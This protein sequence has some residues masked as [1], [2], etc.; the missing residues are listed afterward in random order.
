M[1]RNRFIFLFFLSLFF[2][3]CGGENCKPCKEVEDIKVS[4]VKRKIIEENGSEVSFARLFY[5][6]HEPVVLYGM[7]G[8]AYKAYFEN[9]KWYKKTP[10]TGIK[11]RIDGIFYHG[12]TLILEIDELKLTVVSSDNS[13]KFV[14]LKDILMDKILV[15]YINFAKMQLIDNSVYVAGIINR[16]TIFYIKLSSSFD[17]EK[18]QFVPYDKGNIGDMVQMYVRENGKFT[19]VFANSDEGSIIIAENF[20]SQWKF[21]SI[22][23]SEYH[24]FSLPAFLW[25]DTHKVANIV[26]RDL[27]DGG[28]YYSKILS[29]SVTPTRLDSNSLVGSYMSGVTVESTPYIF[30]YDGYDG[31]VKYLK[32]NEKDS[33][34]NVLYD[35][36]I[37]G[38]YLDAKLVNKDIIGIIFYDVT[39]RKLLYYELRSQEL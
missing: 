18:V 26:F 15:K 28:L 32:I 30:F 37:S 11:G 9:G 5:N 7:K 23:S 39:Y 25:Y 35:R 27:V 21:Y 14:D 34:I 16:K 22:L 36:G 13:V 31:S 3:S 33:M 6:K 19:F 38:F 2:I 10:V 29:D 12:T 17:V 24:S 1:K 20:D 8:K 4:P